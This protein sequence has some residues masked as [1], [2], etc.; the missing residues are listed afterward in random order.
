MLMMRLE[1]ERTLDA[2]IPD[3]AKEVEMLTWIDIEGQ[4]KTYDSFHI[5]LNDDSGYFCNFAF[6]VLGIRVK[7]KCL[8]LGFKD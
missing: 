6:W 5:N 7:A 4:P 1:F 2:E 8:G 3:R